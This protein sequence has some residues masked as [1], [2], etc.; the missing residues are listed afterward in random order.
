MKN[1]MNPLGWSK[2]QRHEAL[3]AGTLTI[4]CL[5]C[6]YFFTCIAK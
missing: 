4:I 2:E 5:A 1:E 3:I 6:V